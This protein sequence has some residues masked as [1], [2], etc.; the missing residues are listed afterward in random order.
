[1][2]DYEVFY[3]VH[4]VDRSPVMLRSLLLASLANDKLVALLLIGSI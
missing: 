4:V 1:M 2:W 3:E